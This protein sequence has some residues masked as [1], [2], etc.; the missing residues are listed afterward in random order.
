MQIIRRAL[1]PGILACIV[2]LPSAAGA[3]ETES[4]YLSTGCATPVIE[5]LLFK[6]ICS[7][8]ET[9]FETTAWGHWGILEANA[10]GDLVFGSEH[11]SASINLW[12]PIFCEATGFWQFSQLLIEDQTASTPALRQIRNRFPCP[13][14]S[15]GTDN[16]LRSLRAI[17]RRRFG[18]EFI[19][20]ISRKATCARILARNVRRCRFGWAIGDSIF[21]G[22]ARVRL[23]VK[24]VSWV[25]GVVVRLNE[26]CLVVQHRPRRTC[27]KRLHM[28]GRYSTK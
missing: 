12:H 24:E 4:V 1:I 21:S 16:A 26:Y 25:R 3:G 15:L 14:P 8:P 11:H 9:T 20:G 17:L 18:T 19:Y 6:P 27:I 2:A 23:D 7:A 22:K 13:L 28:R 10:L 5:P